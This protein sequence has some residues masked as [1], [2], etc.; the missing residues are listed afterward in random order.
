MGTSFIIFTIKFQQ[1]EKKVCGLTEVSWSY[2]SMASLRGKMAF[3]FLINSYLADGTL[4]VVG[5]ACWWSRFLAAQTKSWL[6]SW[7]GS[8]ERYLL[9]SFF[10]W[11]LRS[12]NISFSFFLWFSECTFFLVAKSCDRSATG[13]VTP[14]QHSTNHTLRHLPNLSSTRRKPTAQEGQWTL[15]T[16]I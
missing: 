14:R 6:C 8:L 4:G 7:G 10:G 1:K 9:P 3:C 5:R 12:L 16:R 13:H 15:T 2:F 11:F